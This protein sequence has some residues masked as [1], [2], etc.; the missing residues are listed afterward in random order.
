MS[1]CV[2]LGGTYDVQPPPDNTKLPLRTLES[3]CVVRYIIVMMMMM[4]RMKKMMMKMII[5]Y[6]C[7]YYYYYDRWYH[8]YFYS[9]PEAF[10]HAEAGH[11]G[12]LVGV[13]GLGIGFLV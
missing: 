13:A 4:M 10:L 6:F 1:H 11:C 7:C 8:F 9:W 3:P 12:S 2:L 5:N